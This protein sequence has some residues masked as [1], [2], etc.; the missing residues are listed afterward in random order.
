MFISKKNKYLHKI[1][2]LITVFFLLTLLLGFFFSENASGGAYIDYEFLNPWVVKFSKNTIETLYLYLENKA[3]IIHSPI[4]YIFLGQVLNF[5][6]S[7]EFT[8]FFYIFL[9]S[10]L[11]IIFYK[12][13][14]RKYSNIKN[15]YYLF[16]F[17]NIIFLSPYFRSSAVWGLGDNLSL[18][19]FSLFIF[20][21][22]KL[23]DFKKAIDLFLC[24]TFIILASYLRYYY[25]IY[26]ILILYTI[27]QLKII[28]NFKIITFFFI[29]CLS[30]SLPAL[31]YFL[32]I[33]YNYN[34][35]DTLSSFGSFNLFKSSYEIVIIIL[36]FNIPLI[37]VSLK[38][39]I[40]YY[41]R[42]YRLFIIISLVSILIF[43]IN[44]LFFNNLDN[45]LLG[46]GVFKKLI[47]NF[48]GLKSYYLFPFFLL[49][50]LF[51]DFL[52]KSNR[53]FNYLV[54]FLIIISLPFATI[55]QKY[56]DPLYILILFGL[57]KSKY[58]DELILNNKLPLKILYLYFSF[59]LYFAVIY[60]S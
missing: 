3:L 50:M 21:L 20:F 18:I 57:I 53:F 15:Y 46:G 13:L 24:A 45:T 32:F 25:A 8:R 51:L 44:F 22:N 33:I 38:D 56:L 28:N 10:F 6:G 23:N 58:I 35:L 54:L 34:F 48:L 17:S 55:F 52:M 42:N 16:I 59:Y 43:L 60:Y 40:Q 47:V 11:P 30:L 31:I 26:F 14:K 4:F 2:Y 7:Y 12:I 36:F 1:K 9:S 49:S 5:L 41:I 37:L 29:F 39:F 27:F 19:F